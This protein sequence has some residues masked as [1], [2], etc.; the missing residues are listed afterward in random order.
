MRTLIA[1]VVT[2]LLLAPV[3]LQGWG[4]DVH[5]QITRRALDNLPPELRPFYATHREFIAEHSVDPDM[6]LSRAGASRREARARAMAELA[7]LG[8]TIG[9]ADRL[10]RV[11]RRL[12]RDRQSLARALDVEENATRRRLMLVHG[13]R[14]ALIQRIC[15]LAAVV[16]E[17][18]PDHGVTRGQIQQRLVRLDEAGAVEQLTSI[19]PKEGAGMAEGADF[20]EPATYRPD[21]AL[22]YAMEERELFGPLLRLHELVVRLGGAL[23]HDIGAMG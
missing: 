7:Q 15:L 14:V 20:G 22:S 6:W 23:T 19:F 21:P 2:L 17:F 9:L 8:E 16:P 13:I 5:R 18:S 1:A 3:P 11:V 12:K 10:H 4:V